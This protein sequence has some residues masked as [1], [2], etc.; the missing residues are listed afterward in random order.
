MEVLVGCIHNRRPTIHLTTYT[1]CSDW[2]GGGGGATHL[3][4]LSSRSLYFSTLFALPHPQSSLASF[5]DRWSVLHSPYHSLHT[6]RGSV[7]IRMSFIKLNKNSRVLGSSKCLWHSSIVSIEL[8]SV[9]ELLSC[10]RT[11]L[12][13]VYDPSWTIVQW[14]MCLF[15]HWMRN[16]SGHF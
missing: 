8:L 3:I 12:N 10:Q 15:I 14:I 4:Q 11:C 5:S 7:L 2:S 13:H 16:V 6:N 1:P 9:Q